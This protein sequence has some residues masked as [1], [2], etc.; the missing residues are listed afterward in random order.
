VESIAALSVATK[1]MSSDPD[2]G[3][4]TVPAIPPAIEVMSHTAL[5]IGAIIWDIEPEDSPHAA[6]WHRGM[7]T[8]TSATTI[9]AVSRSLRIFRPTITGFPLRDTGHQSQPLA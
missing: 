2:T 8:T 1:P 5:N 9:I 6:F 3:G 7:A 4:G